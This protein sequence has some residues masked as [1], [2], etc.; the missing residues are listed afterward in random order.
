MVSFY[1][2]IIKGIKVIFPFQNWL[3]FR[4]HSAQINVESKQQEG[5][6]V[7]LLKHS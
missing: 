7:G 1:G 5:E 4:R 6:I 2:K 3:D